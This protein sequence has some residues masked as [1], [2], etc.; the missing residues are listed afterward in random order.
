MKTTNN[1]LSGRLSRRDFIKAATTV[2]LWL[3]GLLGL[4]GLY[5]FFNYKSVPASPSE[6]DLG[7]P[8]AY[9]P[10]SRTIRKD[11]PAVIFNR[12]GQIMAASLV[13][14]HLGCTVEENGS[15]FSCPCHGSRFDQDGHVMEGPAQNPLKLLRIEITEGKTL[16]LHMD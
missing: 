6:Y 13:C 16:K 7:D 1:N 4:G 15:G 5:R 3:G 8:A 11:I 2:L 12:D 9:P 14:T 10:G